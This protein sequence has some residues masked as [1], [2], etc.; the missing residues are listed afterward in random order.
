MQQKYETEK[1]IYN[2]NLKKRQTILKQRSE[3]NLN[4]SMLEKTYL[5]NLDR[6]FTD[7]ISLNI[8]AKGKNE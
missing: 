7:K 5:S 1:Q 4:R 8:W 2:E 3:A 6:K